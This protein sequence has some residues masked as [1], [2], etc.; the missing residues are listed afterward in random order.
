MMRRTSL[1]ILALALLVTAGCA[2]AAGG[3]DVLDPEGVGALPQAP[4]GYD[5]LAP[6]TAEPSPAPTD[7]PR[8]PPP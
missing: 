8:T 1:I 2:R 4:A 3:T 6:A 5:E 7:R